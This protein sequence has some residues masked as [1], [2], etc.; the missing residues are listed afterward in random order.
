MPP[1]PA[2]VRPLFCVF[3]NLGGEKQASK[4]ETGAGAGRKIMLLDEAVGLDACHHAVVMLLAGSGKGQ[5]ASGDAARASKGD[6]VRRHGEQALTTPGQAAT[7]RGE[8][9]VSRVTDTGARR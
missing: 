6:R 5:P 8:K 3:L 7:K 1:V 4:T 9:R 2:S